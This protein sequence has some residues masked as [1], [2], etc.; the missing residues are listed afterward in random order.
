MCFSASASFITS[1]L[2]ITTGVYAIKKT[3]DSKD[4]SFLLLALMPLLFGIQQFSE[5]FIWLFFGKDPNLD[6]LLSL[7]FLF[8]A[9]LLWPVW[10]PLSLGVFDHSRRNFFY[11]VAFGG[12]IYGCLLYGSTIFY[13]TYF[14]LR[15]CDHSICYQIYHPMFNPWGICWYFI[16]TILPFFIA[17]SNIIKVL[18]ILIGCS[19]ILTA[20][21]W[22]H[23]FTSVW[24]FFSAMISTYVG[25]I[26]YSLRKIS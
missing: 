23:A 3:F 20:F 24:C 22:V 17:K 21:F 7:I 25:Y 10:V 14:Y 1:G 9:F 18:G 16:F 12:L 13:P 11:V 19:A 2:L 8:F 5:G 26:A 15:L 6:H 4:H